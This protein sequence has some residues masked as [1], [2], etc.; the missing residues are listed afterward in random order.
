[1]YTYVNNKPNTDIYKH[2]YIHISS[3]QKRGLNYQ[4]VANNS[5]RPGMV[6]SIGNILLNWVKKYLI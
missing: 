6:N 4:L 5:H 2:F 3:Y 1:M